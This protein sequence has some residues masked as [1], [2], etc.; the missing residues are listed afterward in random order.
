MKRAVA[1]RLRE[2]AEVIATA[3]REISATIGSRIP[4]TIKIAGGTTGLFIVAGG[5][6]A[7][8]AA[9]FEN[10]SWHPVYARG[11]RSGWAWRRQPKKPFLEEAYAV[12]GEEAA[13]AFASVIDDWCAE[14]DI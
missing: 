10:G 3:A 11:P 6:A 12:S 8:N 14:L 1:K 4:A 13:E 7:P 5:E 9:P 2:A